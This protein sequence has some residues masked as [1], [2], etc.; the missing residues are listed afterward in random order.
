MRIFSL[1]VFDGTEVPIVY[2]LFCRPSEDSLQQI[3]IPDGSLSKDWQ[4]TVGWGECWIRPRTSVS[5]SG[6]ATNEPPRLPMGIC[7][8]AR[9][10]NLSLCP[11][12]S[13]GQRSSRWKGS[14]ASVAFSA[15]QWQHRRNSPG[16]TWWNSCTILPPYATYLE[17]LPLLLE[18]S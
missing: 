7:V 9:L 11:V 17:Q 6:V 15:L 10:L 4:S 5:Q 12:S 1:I 14:A 18:S 8:I 16:L 2:I 3:P 13:G